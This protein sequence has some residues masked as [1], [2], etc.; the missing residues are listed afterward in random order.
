[1]QTSALWRVRAMRTAL[2]SSVLA[3]Q[4][5]ARSR[6]RPNCIWRASKRAWRCAWRGHDAQH[7]A[8]AASQ[9]R[10]NALLTDF[11]QGKSFE[12]GLCHDNFAI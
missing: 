1:M 4:L 7:P 12:V 6:L 8:L 9:Q 2:G 10:L 5:K 11:R 3:I